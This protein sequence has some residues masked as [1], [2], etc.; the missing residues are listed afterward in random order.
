MVIPKNIEITQLIYLPA[1]WQVFEHGHCLNIGTCT[2]LQLQYSALQ[3]F[4]IIIFTSENGH[5]LHFKV[6]FLCGYNNFSS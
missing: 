2:V 3:I 5:V 6:A 1:N 4:N